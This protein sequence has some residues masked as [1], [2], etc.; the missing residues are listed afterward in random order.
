MPK[1]EE[2]LK[3]ISDDTVDIKIDVIE[4]KTVL[5]GVPNTEDGGLVREIRDMREN[6][7]SLNKKHNK[8]SQKFWILVAFLAGSGVLGAGIWGLFSA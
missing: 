4:I 6:Q 5:L 1:L 7:D 2:Q 8:L 3:Q